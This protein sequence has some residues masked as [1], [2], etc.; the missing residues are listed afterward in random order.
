MIDAAVGM[1]KTYIMAA[2]MDYFA[3]GQGVRNFAI[4]TPGSTILRKTVA[5]FTR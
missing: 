4:V 1:G 2:T 5:N 3:T